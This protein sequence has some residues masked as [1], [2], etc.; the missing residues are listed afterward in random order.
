LEVAWPLPE[1]AEDPDIISCRQCVLDA[2]R[3]NAPPRLDGDI[4]RPIDFMR[5]RYAHDAG[6]GLLL[7]KQCACLGM[8][9]TEHP[10][11]RASDK[12]EVAGGCRHRTPRK[13]Y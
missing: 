6:V 9:G 1:A 12:D 2:L 11:I 3:V 4:F 8:K 10:V 13:G 7:P 5:D